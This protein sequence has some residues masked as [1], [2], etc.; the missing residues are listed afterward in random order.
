M[1][2]CSRSRAAPARSSAS[3]RQ[4][5]ALPE[6]GR[7]TAPLGKVLFARKARQ[8]ARRPSRVGARAFSADARARVGVGG[9]RRRSRSGSRTRLRIEL[10]EAESRRPR[11]RE[12]A[13]T[14]ELAINRQQQQI[15]FDR[16]QVQTLERAR[17]TWPPSSMGSKRAAN[18]RVPGGPG[19]APR[20]GGRGERGTR[21]RVGDAGAESVP[22]VA[23]H[24]EI[25]GLEADVEA[26]RS[27]V[28]SAINS[29]TALRHA[30][31]HLGGARIASATCCPSSTSK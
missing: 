13:H 27:E 3:S 14:R 20:W 12:A 30:L 22:Y 17:R 16:E 26:A 31:E 4:G 5:A 18:P 29:A 8:L 2:S 10:V 6:T 19:S 15:V 9:A 23:A 7:R 21:S 1:T 24:R 28:F 11:S 25:E